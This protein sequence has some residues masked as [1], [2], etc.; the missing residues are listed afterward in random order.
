MEKT[1]LSNKFCVL[2]P[3]YKV[4]CLSSLTSNRLIPW[5]AKG[6]TKPFPLYGICLSAVLASNRPLSRLGA[7]ARVRL[8]GANVGAGRPGPAPPG[9]TR[10]VKTHLLFSPGHQRRC[11]HRHATRA[12]LC[13]SCQAAPAVTAARDGRGSPGTSR[14]A[15]DPADPPPRHRSPER[16]ASGSDWQSQV[17]SAGWTL[18]SAGSR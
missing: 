8:A 11:P 15:L 7:T 1:G 4:L 5:G 3:S 17:L 10:W 14:G 16:L 2:F 12:G 9:F 13:S 18:T 6:H